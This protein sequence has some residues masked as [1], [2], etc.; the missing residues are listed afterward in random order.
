M[1]YFNGVQV[2]ATHALEQ[3]RVYRVPGRLVEGGE[4]VIA[5]RVL[6]TGGDGGLNYDGPSLRLSLSDDR[7]IPLSGPW[8]YRVGSELADLPAPPVQPDFDPHR[9]TALYHSM[10]RPLVPLAFRGA[11]WYQG[12][13]NAW[14]GR[15][16]RDAFPVARRGLALVLGARFPVPVRAVG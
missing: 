2:G 12:E 15:A 6:D 13:S 10:L 4:A 8:R 11:V 1:T 16:V 7:Y 3:E 5:I 9:P 14:A